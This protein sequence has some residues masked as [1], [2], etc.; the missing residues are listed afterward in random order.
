MAYIDTSNAFSARRL[1]AMLRTVASA[2]V[3]REGRGVLCVPTGRG[4]GQRV[5]AFPIPS[6]PC[7]APPL[8]PWARCGGRRG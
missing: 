5:F 4:W 2:R 8:L 3:V 7:A 6:P 1:E